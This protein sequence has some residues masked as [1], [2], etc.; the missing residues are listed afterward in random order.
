MVNDSENPLDAISVDQNGNVMNVV[1]KT[2]AGRRRKFR[3]QAAKDLAYQITLKE[4]LKNEDEFELFLE[5]EHQA[6]LDAAEAKAAAEAETA[7]ANE[8]VP[9]TEGP[10][11]GPVTGAATTGGTATESGVGVSTTPADTVLGLA[12]DARTSGVVA[13][14]MRLIKILR[15]KM[16]NLDIVIHD[17]EESYNAVMNSLG[18]VVG[19]SGAFSYSKEG[20]GRGI[21]GRIDINL[22]SADASTVSHEVA[23]AL[24]LYTFGDKPILFKKFRDKISAVIDQASNE[25]LTEFAS[26]YDE[27][28][29]HEEYLVELAAILS[30]QASRIDRTTL[31][32]IAKVVNEIVSSITGG[33]LKPF[34]NIKDTG[35]V[36]NF[37]NNMAESLRNG[38][39][40]IPTEVQMAYRETDTNS[41]GL[42][43]EINA[44]GVTS[45]SSI[46]SG[47]IKRFPVNPNAT[48]QEEVPLSSLNG[49]RVNLM[50]SDR[51]TGGYIANSEGNPLY[52]F[53]G[54][55]FYPIITGK[56]RRC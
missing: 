19:S 24:M 26:Q 37:F 55:V 50:E 43:G 47:E 18:G 6:E 9:T 35:E 10:T 38:T 8:P 53:Y 16:P 42:S 51:M 48:V 46:N 5:Q 41:L 28:V 40:F 49:K 32:K 36:V 3:G 39:E 17:T 13:T 12:K 31:E 34:Q 4:T 15:D 14:A 45:K 56:D 27:E 21:V 30:G 33:I 20:S 2:P 1:L 29:S 52:K 23:H 54:G 22:S 44:T 25:R 11:T 7:A